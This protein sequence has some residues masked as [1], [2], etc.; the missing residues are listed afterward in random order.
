[1]KKPRGKK[2]SERRKSDTLIVSS[3]PEGNYHA[4]VMELAKNNPGL[5]QLGKITHV[6]V[7]HDDWCDVYEGRACNCN[8]DVKLAT[9]ET[10]N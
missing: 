9:D 4:K 10:Q 1:M 7:A 8:P 6:N 5:F 2:P 3:Q